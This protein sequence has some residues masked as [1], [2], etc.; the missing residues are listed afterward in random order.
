MKACPASALVGR[1][2]QADT[3]VSALWCRVREKIEQRASSIVTLM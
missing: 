3:G 1:R 2:R